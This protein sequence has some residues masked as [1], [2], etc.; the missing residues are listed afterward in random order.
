MRLGSGIGTNTTVR[1]V[2]GSVNVSLNRNGID[3]LGV[4]QGDFMRETRA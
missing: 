3:R 1:H 4:S 2:Y